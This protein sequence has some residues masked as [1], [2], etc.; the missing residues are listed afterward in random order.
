MVKIHLSDQDLLDRNLKFFLFLE[1]NM[2]R[3]LI[4][5]ASEEK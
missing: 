3:V 2:L 5:S 4:R 1:E